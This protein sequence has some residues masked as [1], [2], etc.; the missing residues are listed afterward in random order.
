MSQMLGSHSVRLIL[1]ALSVI[2]VMSSLLVGVTAQANA[3]VED[4]APTRTLAGVDSG[5]NAPNG[6]AFDGSGN[7]YVVNAMASSVT[8][9]PAGWANGDTAPTKTLIGA[10]TGL[11]TPMG[12]TFD[13]EG[14]M[15]VTNQGEA[16]SV[17]M[18]TPDWIETPGPTSDASPTHTLRTGSGLSDPTDIEVDSE[19]RLYVTNVEDLA[20]YGS[21]WAESPAPIKVLYAEEGMSW[22]RALA[23]DAEGTMYVAN[24][25]DN[26][27]VVYSSNWLN[28][29]TPSPVKRISGD[30]TGIASPHGVALDSSGDLYVTNYAASSV[31]K[32][33]SSADGDVEPAVT[34]TGPDSGV[35]MPTGITVDSGGLNVYVTNREPGKEAVLE[36]GTDPTV[37]GISPSVGTVTGGQA[38][39][40]T[41][42]GLA[43]GATVEIGGV[44]CTNP[45]VVSSTSITCTTGAHQAGPAA[46]VVENPDTL[47]GTL[48]D[49]FTY[50]S[51]GVAQ[52]IDFTLQPRYSRALRVLNFTA[53]ASSGLPVVV[54]SLTTNVCTVVGNSLRLR[55]TGTCS[56]TAEQAGNS[57]YSPASSVAA[58]VSIVSTPPTLLEICPTG[59]CVNV[60]LR[61]VHLVGMDLTGV[62]FTGAS[63]SRANFVGAKLDGAN[64]TNAD[65]SGTNLTKIDRPGTRGDSPASVHSKRVLR[66]VNFT[67]ATLRNAQLSGIELRRVR[68]KSANLRGAK[69]VGSW[70]G[71][72]DF[73][74]AVFNNA[75]LNRA[76]FIN[77]NLRKA[78]F[79]NAKQRQ[80]RY[81]DSPK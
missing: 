70:V 30:A 46:V 16:Q 7:M 57:V 40:V 19:G 51:S 73:A 35:G 77:T 49:G 18:Y 48:A 62:N 36:F 66:S 12:I 63:L 26:S 20:A 43:I 10:S 14:N 55:A 27:I 22:P 58:S 23:F 74:K 54:T 44:P 4:R 3:A 60:N 59:S 68:G 75:N 8:M 67:R 21:N 42:T 72:S 45:E 61:N 2:V 29:G 25:A 39:T 52:T 1:A 24:A 11:D 15:Y 33:D 76:V 17:T 69:L 64:F 34:I 13:D 47:T 56:V 28:E 37:T 6:V 41:G 78:S 32:F 80:T 50:E 65:L 53:T 9:Y 79:N 71:N 5:L 81:I 31:L 38:V